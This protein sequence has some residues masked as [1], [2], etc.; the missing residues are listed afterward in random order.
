MSHKLLPRLGSAIASTILSV[1][2]GVSL[3]GVDKAQAVELTYNFQVG[4]GGGSNLNFFKMNNSSLTGIGEEYIRVSD[5]RLY[6]FT[7]GGKQY[8]NLAG[9]TALF[10]QGDFLGL[11]AY[12][13]D[14][15]TRSELLIPP[16]EPGGPLYLQSKSNISWSITNKR[17]GYTTW[18]PSVLS[19]YS[20]AYT[21]YNGETPNL[22]G[23]NF[24]DDISVSYTLVDTE[25]EP[26]P[27]PLTAGGTAL[28]FAGLSWLKQ[29]KK[30][31]A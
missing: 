23:R 16:D 28:A 20:E 11:N 29:K 19:G 21:A 7:V 3:V 13:S 8:N 4:S 26:V 27:E 15:A 24:F 30:M 18:N 5:G 1:F 31:A 12:G 25:A 14:Y 9:A 22:A 10:Y 6:G 2:S 17:T